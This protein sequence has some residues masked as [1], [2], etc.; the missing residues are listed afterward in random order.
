MTR[1]K[2]G[3]FY[4]A[5]PKKEKLDIVVVRVN[6]S[7]EICNARPCF[8]CLNMMKSVGI[9]RVYYSVGPDEIIYENVK[10][11][12][13][14][15]ASSVTLL[16]EKINGNF[17][18]DEPEKYYESLLAKL[19]P[20]VIRKDNLEKFITHNLS[21]VLPMYEVKIDDK[22]HSVWILDTNKK[23]IVRSKIQSDYCSFM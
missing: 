11:M 10:D 6:R 21:N 16:I 9:R 14:I 17:F 7:G 1:K 20:P 18:D 4:G 23:P 22:L 15:Q 13:S 19:F 2:G 12:V 8:N 3:V 5:K